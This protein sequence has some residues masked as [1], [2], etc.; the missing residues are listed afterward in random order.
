ML[1]LEDKHGGIAARLVC[2]FNAHRDRRTC[3]D[4]D[5]G[6]RYLEVFAQGRWVE[7]R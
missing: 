4:F 7:A 1:V 6:A 3:V 5:T 2:K